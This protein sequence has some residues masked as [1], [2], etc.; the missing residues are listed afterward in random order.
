MDGDKRARVSIQQMELSKVVLCPLFC[1]LCTSMTWAEILVKL[2]EVLLRASSYAMRKG[3]TVNTSKSEVMHFSS[4]SYPSLPIFMYG[5]L[6]LP[7]KK[8]FRY[9][10]MLV[11]KHMDLK[12][13]EEHA[14]QP[15]MAAQQRIKEFV[16]ELDL[17][18]RPH[19]LIWLSKV[20]GIP[21]GMYA[22]Q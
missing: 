5:D 18:N 6:A 2:Q 8:Q 13:S 11:D 14:V 7:E 3:L 22:C 12:V 16:Y 20:Y 4:R 1:F 21:A 17:R 19:D 10:G 9:L 15:Y